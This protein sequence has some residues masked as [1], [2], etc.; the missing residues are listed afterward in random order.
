MS[1]YQGGTALNPSLK[2]ADNHAI[3]GGDVVTP[4]SIGATPASRTVNGK[5]LSADITL[6][7]SDVGARPNTWIPSASD[8]GVYTKSETD[9]LLA[10]AGSKPT[11]VLVTLAS[12]SWDNSA[13]TQTVTV[14]GVVADETSQL[15]TPVPAMASRTAYYD[16][17]ILCTAQ[18]EN[19]LTFTASTVPTEDLTVYI[20]LQEL[21]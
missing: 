14:T 13:L 11:S 1:I 15:I 21:A 4:E 20:V 10:N 3:G 12:A 18:A 2:H 17:G 8:V 9:A 5:A 19:S 7:A 6:S 16:A